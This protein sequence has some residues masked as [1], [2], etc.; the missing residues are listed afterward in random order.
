[1]VLLTLY[2]M[3]HIKLAKTW[4]NDCDLFCQIHREI[5]FKEFSNFSICESLHL[6]LKEVV[7]QSSGVTLGN[8]TFTS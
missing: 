2:N 4:Y 7:T 8:C 1:M 5:P 3:T 6:H